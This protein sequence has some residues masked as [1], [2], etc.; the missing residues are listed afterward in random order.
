MTQADRSFQRFELAA[1]GCVSSNNSGQI[2]ERIHSKGVS[3]PAGWSL[4]GSGTY[5]PGPILSGVWP[6]ELA[7]KYMMLLLRAS[8]LA[9][10]GGQTAYKKARRMPVFSATAPRSSRPSL[11]ESRS[12][13][14]FNR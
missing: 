14:A 2:R 4:D 5:S 9:T 10:T 12:G 3:T 11:T 1:L 13:V 7:A 6:N 8:A